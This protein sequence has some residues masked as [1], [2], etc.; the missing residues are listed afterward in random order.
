VTCAIG[1]REVDSR[2]KTKGL[3]IVGVNVS[4]DT[5]PSARQFVLDRQVPYPVGRDPGGE[6]AKRYGVDATPISF[7]ISRTGELVEKIVGLMDEG[8]LTARLNALL[9]R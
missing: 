1:E 6:I 2:W 5:E 3:E 9:A 4:W 8:E 7:F